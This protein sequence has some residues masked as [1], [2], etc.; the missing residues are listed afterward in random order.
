MG[1]P[2]NLAARAHLYNQLLCAGELI[3][4]F[5]PLT[6][7]QKKKNPLR[8]LRLERSG[9]EIKLLSPQLAAA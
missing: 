7:N 4:G 9:C 1:I 6:K 5:G 3:F 2:L 8:T